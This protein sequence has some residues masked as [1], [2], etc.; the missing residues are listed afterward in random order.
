MMS[1]STNY[2]EL[3]KLPLEFKI[4]RHELDRSYRTLQQTTHPDRY[5]NETSAVQR[6]AVQQTAQNTEAYQALKSPVLR[7][8]HLLTSLGYPFDLSAYTVKDIDLLMQ[9]MQYREQLADIKEAA[10]MDDLMAFSNS[11]KKLTTD[12]VAV[13]EEQFSKNVEE[14]LITIKNNVCELQFLNKLAFDLEEVEEQL[15]FID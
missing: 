6:Q 10:N 2:F 15:M 1:Q 12:T 5:V 7:A 14:H 3:F 13:L 4:N 8:C 9:Q 11:V